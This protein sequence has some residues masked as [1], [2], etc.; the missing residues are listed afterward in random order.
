MGTGGSGGNG[1]RPDSSRRGFLGIVGGAAA[2][3]LAGVVLGATSS[4]TARKAAQP[5]RAFDPALLCRPQ[6]KAALEARVAQ[7]V[8][9]GREP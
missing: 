8:Q 4:D 1:S 7:R 5:V 9:S 3:A 2:A 6:T